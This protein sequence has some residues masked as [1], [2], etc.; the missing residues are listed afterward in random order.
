MVNSKEVLKQETEQSLKYLKDE[1]VDLSQQIFENPE[2]G[3][4][5]FFASGLLTDYLMQKG[6]EIVKP[7]AGLETA[8]RA[9]Y[10]NQRKPLIALL[11]EYD[12]LP[13]LGH[14][15]GHN[16][17]GAA[18]TG[19]AVLIKMLLEQGKLAGQ[20]A[21]FGTPAEE[22]S[23]GKVTMVNKKC[24]NGIDAALMFHPGDS[25]SIDISSLT[26]EAYEFVYYGK[27]AHAAAA[28]HL[29]VNALDGVIQLFNSINSARQY[30]EEEVKIHGIIAEGGVT[31]NIIP[32]RAV[33]RFYIRAS[34]K[35]KLERVVETILDCAK[36]AALSTGCKVTWFNYEL[37]YDEMLTN[38]TLAKV[39]E[40]NLRALGVSDIVPNR[41]GGGSID[42]G[43]V[44]QVVP[45]IHPYISLDVP[46]NC[47]AHTKEFAQAVGSKRGHQLLLLAT[48]ALAFTVIDLLAEPELL[49][50]A[51]EEL[52]Y[53]R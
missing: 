20:I 38:K 8:F 16:L 35:P 32:D 25:T 1:I 19:A 29:A 18:S 31:P 43:N 49:Q 52:R 47:S 37:S 34:N 4:Q 12:A 44:S 11:A 53:K 39:F 48:K 30:M 50:Q 24:F 51:R 36:G 46:G 22:T 7:I 17:I 21:V 45:A 6:F 3:H 28:P 2:L 40:K 26:M 15:C 9:H 27:S 14:G 41:P 23:G 42:M 5:E 10:G 33:A 13:N